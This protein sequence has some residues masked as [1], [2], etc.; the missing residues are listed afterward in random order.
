[1]IESRQPQLA[2]CPFVPISLLIL[3][4]NSHYQLT[5]Y[6]EK[7]K[8]QHYCLK[9]DTVQSNS[10][11]YA[12]YFPFLLYE[13]VALLSILKFS[14]DEQDV[15][16]QYFQQAAKFLSKGGDLCM[17]NNKSNE[18][19]LFFAS[20]LDTIA[21]DQEC[22]K[23]AKEFFEALSIKELP[24]VDF[25]NTNCKDPKEILRACYENNQGLI[26]G[27][28]HN[29]IAPKKFL[30]DNMS[31]LKKLGVN[32]L[33]LEN[34]CYHTLQPLL[35]RYYES[36]P[37]S[38]M[39]PFLE[40]VLKNVEKSLKN[41]R[42]NYANVVKVAKE[43][44]IRVVAIDLI[45]NK[46]DNQ[47]IVNDGDASRLTTLNFHGY[48]VIKRT[49]SQES[50]SKFV[51]LCGAGHMTTMDDVHGFA[52]IGGYPCIYVSTGYGNAKMNVSKFTIGKQV[53]GPA[54]CLFYIPE[55]KCSENTE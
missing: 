27:E 31:C 37:N 13:I 36:P 12:I 23:Q 20:S 51:V 46:A 33:F 4:S 24:C 11:W 42:F 16:E 17:S 52:Q 44:K 50:A 35:N 28:A 29:C 22:Q 21:Y 48:Q 30:I 14:I 6:L 2:D 47:W 45:K 34:V 18:F 7:N 5:N 15:L 43:E 38:E 55:Y 19:K 8:I 53:L 40:E 25:K 1:M 3:D 26:L 41:I 49:M 32:I 39:D 9:Q 10:G 54:N